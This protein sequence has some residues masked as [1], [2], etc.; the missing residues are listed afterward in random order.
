[1]CATVLANGRFWQD[2]G[3]VGEG[4]WRLKKI[5]HPVSIALP[6]PYRG[7]RFVLLGKEIYTTMGHILFMLYDFALLA[8]RFK[9]RDSRKMS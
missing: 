4:F 8:G 9:A 6:T 1:M 7:K 5:P 3:V 2:R